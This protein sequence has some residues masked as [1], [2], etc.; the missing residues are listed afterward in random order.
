MHRRSSGRKPTNPGSPSPV[1]GNEAHFQQER[2]RFVRFLTD[3]LADGTS[4]AGG[5]MTNR[6]SFITWEE[7]RQESLS[8][9]TARKFW[10]PNDDGERK[11]LHSCREISFAP[12][13]N[14]AVRPAEHSGRWFLPTPPVITGHSEVIL[15]KSPH[16]RSGGFSQLVQE[17]KKGHADDGVQQSE[18]ECALDFKSDL[19]AQQAAREHPVQELV[20]EVEEERQQEPDH[21]VLHVD[22]QADGGGEVPDQSLDD[23]EHA[24]RLLDGQGV[25]GQADESADKQ[26]ADLAAAHQRKIDGD[27]QRQ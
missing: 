16:R 8:P 11:P 6:T 18:H 14:Q 27:E 5:S 20:E 1:A 13:S 24:E 23:A 22:A 19:A 9:K 17:M 7:T 21:G 4:V 25:L 3:Q 2:I 12:A 15:H 10:L 26:S